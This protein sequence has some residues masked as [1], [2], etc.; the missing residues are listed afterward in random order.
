MDKIKIL[1]LYE[2]IGTGHKRT[3][4][5]LKKAFEKRENVEASIENPFGEKFPS[6][7][8]LTTR[9]YLKTLKL[10][11]ELWGYLYEME[12]DKIERRINKLVG[13]SIYTF[14]KDY[15]LSLKPDAVICTHP[16]CCSILSH[17][18]RDLNIPIYA[19]LTDYDVHAYWIHHQID[20]YFVGSN[21]M[22]TQMKNMGV[23]D[24]KIYVTGIP[25]DEEF[26]VRKDKFEVR[27]KLG[28]SLDKPLVLVMGGGLG[29]GN[30]KK[31]V[32]VIQNYKDIQIAVLC[33]FNKNLKSKLE[34]IAD[35]NVKVFGHVD[36]VH[37]FMEAADVLITKSG[38]LTITEAITKKLPMIVFDPI[39]GQEER[40]LEF[41]LRKRIALRIKDIEKLDKKIMDLLGDSKKLNEMKER[42]EE[43]DIYDSADKV[44]HI[45][46]N[47]IKRDALKV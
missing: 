12:R 38:G 47:N 9:I 30:M 15:V 5:A 17:V 22:K 13:I 37:D 31:A 28:F 3:A 29:L 24:D 39:P 19:I 8:Y 18:K 41:L 2:D 43:L 33:G 16:F 1:I 34:E 11:P 45:V 4:M 36:N 7:S 20:G 32:K 21:E 42:M 14:I 6:L 10:T 35:D 26:Y 40:N 25:I 23:S 46:I 44:C 27:Q